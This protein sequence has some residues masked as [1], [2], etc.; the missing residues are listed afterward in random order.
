MKTFGKLYL[1][2]ELEIGDIINYKH[3]PHQFNG[4]YRGKA[5]FFRRNGSGKFDS[6]QVDLKTD[7]QVQFLRAV[8]DFEPKVKF[9][10]DEN[11]T[12]FIDSPMPWGKYAGVQMKD[13]P[14]KYLLFMYHSNYYRPLCPVLDYVKRN[15]LKK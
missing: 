14:E 8:P 3:K 11:K 4:I 2:H 7:I 5:V 6:K 9:T 12:L 15:L 13:V 10:P 1:I